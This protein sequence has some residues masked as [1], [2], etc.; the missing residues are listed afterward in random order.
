MNS[1]IKILGDLMIINLRGELDHHTSHLIKLQIEKGMEK[2]EIKKMLFNFKSVTFM[3]SSGIGLII[4]RHKEL[5]KIGGTIGISN[6]NP[7]VKK[8]FEMSGLFGI[9]PYFD[10]EKEALEKL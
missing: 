9:I 7:Q 1:T 4:G 3:D 5:K 6:L 8:V 10:D 2:H